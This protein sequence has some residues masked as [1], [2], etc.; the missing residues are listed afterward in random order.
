MDTLIWQKGKEKLAFKHTFLVTLYP[1]LDFFAKL[2]FI[3]TLFLFYYVKICTVKFSAQ[4]MVNLFVWYVF[5]TTVQ[6]A[7]FDV[8][9]CVEFFTFVYMMVTY[10]GVQKNAIFLVNTGKSPRYH[11]PLQN[12]CTLML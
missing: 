2:K 1:S 10:S 9:C 8:A 4:F 12:L 6:Q 3:G 11:W 5:I 7:A